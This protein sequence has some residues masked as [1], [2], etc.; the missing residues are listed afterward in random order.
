MGAAG[1]PE[2]Y[3]KSAKE[4]AG[5]LKDDQVNAVLFSPV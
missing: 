3:E 5:L 2:A 4:V 1:G